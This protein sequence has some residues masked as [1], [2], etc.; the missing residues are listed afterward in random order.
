MA[1]YIADQYG[2]NNDKIKFDTNF[3][4]G[5]FRKTMG[6]ERFRACLKNYVFTDLK[7]GL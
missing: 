2:I 7:T 5:Q 4:D 1:F 6:N 3:S